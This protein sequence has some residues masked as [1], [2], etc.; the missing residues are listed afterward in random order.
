MLAFEEA[1]GPTFCQE[2]VQE[3]VLLT[4]LKQALTKLAQD[5]IMEAGVT[6]F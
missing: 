4:M 1:F 3:N 2:F 5:R 6:Q